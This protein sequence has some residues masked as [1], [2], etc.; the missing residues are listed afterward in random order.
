M[1]HYYT[2]ILYKFGVTL[3]NFL[4]AV[5]EFGDLLSQVFSLVRISKG[6]NLLG[7]FPFNIAETAQTPSLWSFSG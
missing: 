6:A 1:G 4:L 2:H 5:V 7:S 3:A